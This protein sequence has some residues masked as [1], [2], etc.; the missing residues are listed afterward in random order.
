MT[1]KSETIISVDGLSKHYRMWK[2]PGARL[3]APLL[4]SFARIFPRQ[5]RV[6][7]WALERAAQHYEDFFAIEDVSF[8]I[9]R[10]ESVGI[11]GRN[12]SGKSTL[13]KILTGI[14]KPSSG[15]GLV[16]GK[17]A[18]LLELGS[19]F[20]PEFS[21]REN[22]YLNGAL[23]GLSDR[24]IDQRYE[25]IVQFADIG[26][27]IDQ[28][29]RTYSSGMFVRLAFAVAV[30]V[31]PEIL[32]VDEVLAVGDIFFRQ[33]C[34]QHMREKMEGVSRLLV[35]HDMHAII[36]LCSRVLVMD[37]GRLVFDGEPAEAVE[38]YTKSFHN[39]AYGNGQRETVGPVAQEKVKPA[40]N[41]DEVGI[42]WQDVDRDD[43]SG[44]GEVLIRKLAVDVE[45]VPNG[46]VV[47]PGDTLRV[48][49]KVDAEKS[50]SDMIFGYI[51][52][53]RI[54]NAVFAENSLSSNGPAAL[55]KGLSR[56]DFEFEWPEIRPGEYLLT[57]GV[58]EGVDPIEHVIQCWVQNTKVFDLICPDRKLHS[59]FNNPITSFELTP[60]VSRLG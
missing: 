52:R 44:R 40:A 8:N 50:K 15:K 13:L 22:I 23:W 2:D 53:D 58:G 39:D 3:K 46:R 17:S 32:I 57:L 24:E 37:R 45:D 38:F 18:A 14:L 47:H 1:S 7:C 55:E 27:F 36:S 30:N 28:P 29:V 4:D 11:I 25:R 26:K 16:D 42:D 51:V 9:A 33:K 31:D 21:G 20:N 19:G 41:W 56:I 12:G 59:L 34:L 48:H 6:H 43:C 10:G 60:N 54:G 49:L 35:S 5:S